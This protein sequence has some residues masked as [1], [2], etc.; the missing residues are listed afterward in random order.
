MLQTK[1][2]K[3][4]WILATSLTLQE[5]ER[6]QFSENNLAAA[7]GRKLVTLNETN[8]PRYQDVLWQIHA[9]KDSKL[10]AK[11]IYNGQAHR[12]DENCELKKARKSDNEDRYSMKEF[13]NSNL[14]W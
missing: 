10:H 3:C 13:R 6:G 7:S 11:A 12:H 5:N 8:S 14:R 4:E 9:G 1:L 2:A